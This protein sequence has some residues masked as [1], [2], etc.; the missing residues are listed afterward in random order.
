M[1]PRTSQNDIMRLLPTV[2]ISTAALAWVSLSAPLASAGEPEG[3]V[4]APFVAVSWAQ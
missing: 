2:V 4:V 1:S 3:Y